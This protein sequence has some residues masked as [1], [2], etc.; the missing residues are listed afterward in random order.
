MRS[1]TTC[2]I[3]EMIDE[4]YLFNT[5]HVLIVDIKTRVMELKT[6]WTSGYAEDCY[7]K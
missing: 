3:L 7:K 5:R 2:E 4:L 6:E 1:S